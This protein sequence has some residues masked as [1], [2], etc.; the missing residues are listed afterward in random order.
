MTYNALQL[1][2][3]AGDP[4]IA[5]RDRRTEGSAEEAERLGIV[6]K[7]VP[8][9]DLDVEARKMAEQILENVPET[10]STMKALVNQSMSLD[11][12]TGLEREAAYHDNG[13]ISPSQVGRQRMEGFLK[14]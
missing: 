12:D 6:N 7:V 8:H 11:L 9:D 5:P 2:K 10:I 1:E 4:A 13:P 3:N 14:K